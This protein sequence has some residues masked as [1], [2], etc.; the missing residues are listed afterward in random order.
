MMATRT[1]EV[2]ELD[3]VELRAACLA[4]IAVLRQLIASPITRDARLEL[5]DRLNHVLDLH[6]RVLRRQP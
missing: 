4:R 6:D 1:I 3:L 2:T 5:Q